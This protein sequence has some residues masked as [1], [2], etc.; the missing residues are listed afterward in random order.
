MVLV[1][2]MSIV[3]LLTAVIAQPEYESM[4]AG[5]VPRMPTGSLLTIVALIG[6][7]VVPY[8]LFLHAGAVIQRWSEVPLEQSLPAARR[9]T[10]IA[11][12]VGGLITLAVL[13]TAASTFFGTSKSFA[14]VGEMA[15][16]LGPLF[17]PAARYFFAAGLLA[18]GFTSAITA[19]LAAAY[20]T[21]GVLGWKRD[22]RAWK[23]RAVWAVIVIAGTILAA[24]ATRP[25]AAIVFA[26][27][28]NGILLPFIAIF[29]LIVMNRRDLLGEYTNGVGSNLM[30][31]AVV[32]VAMAL[33]SIQLLTAL[34]LV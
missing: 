26:Q 22:L 32:L 20:A 13:A 7:T 2:L 27:A 12:S 17:G 5:M 29:L 14:T 9:D 28:A 34:G 31:A 10:C 33:G 3:F 25:V 11:I 15:E 24:I 16:Q 23:L 18:A 6:T 30:G 19:P 21:A 8:N 4:A 1:V